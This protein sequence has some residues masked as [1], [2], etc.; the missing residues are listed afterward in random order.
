ME[1]QVAVNFEL[2][3][4]AV[5]GKNTAVHPKIVLTRDMMERIRDLCYASRA[6]FVEEKEDETVNTYI[7]DI[8]AN[9]FGV[10][11]IS[12]AKIDRD[13]TGGYC[14]DGYVILLKSQPGSPLRKIAKGFS[15][16]VVMS[17][18][19]CMIPVKNGQ[20]VR[21]AEKKK[22]VCLSN[23]MQVL[24]FKFGFSLTGHYLAFRFIRLRIDDDSLYPLISFANLSNGVV[25]TVSAC[26]TTNDKLFIAMSD[27]LYVWN[28]V[29]NS[30]MR[31]VKRDRWTSNS[32]VVQL[33]D[34]TV[35]VVGGL[36]AYDLSDDLSDDVANYNPSWTFAIHIYDP[37]TM[38]C[39]KHSE[40]LSAGES[41]ICTCLPNGKVLISECDTFN[42][43]DNRNDYSMLNSELYDPEENIC[44]PVETPNFLINGSVKHNDMLVFSLFHDLQKD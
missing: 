19:A 37:D 36:C 29:E 4:T 44:T 41:P 3:Q 20:T 11:P 38:E 39:V 23:G 30:M 18:K 16:T 10:G 32:S 5:I 2:L 17:E 24:I 42:F 13:S 34:G 7:L 35:M 33:R 1:K 6:I 22:K 8:D 43:N 27:Y 25:N 28:V 26:L 14:K 21:A 12:D 9:K 31:R 15:A 40:R